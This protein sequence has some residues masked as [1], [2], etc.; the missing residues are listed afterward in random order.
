MI[1]S[2]VQSRFHEGAHPPQVRIK[3]SDTALFRNPRSRQREDDKLP[4]SRRRKLE[5]SDKMVESKLPLLS[6]PSGAYI[7]RSD[8]C[9]VHDNKQVDEVL[10]DL[11][12]YIPVVD[13]GALSSQP[14]SHYKDLD[15]DKL[16]EGDLFS[17]Q[18]VGVEETTDDVDLMELYNEELN[19]IR[20]PKASPVLENDTLTIVGHDYKNCCLQYLVHD[21]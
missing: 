12:Q 14:V 18:V 9:L 16:H 6:W 1:R 17:G 2:I 11:G 20:G 13:E 7:K 4:P 3:I 5:I 15:E 21:N 19:T 10:P 8:Y